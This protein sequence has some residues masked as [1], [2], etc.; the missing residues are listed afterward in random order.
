MKLPFSQEEKQRI[1]DEGPYNAEEIY[2]MTTAYS[3]YDLER[4]GVDDLIQMLHLKFQLG[5]LGDKNQDLGCDDHSMDN[6]K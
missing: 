6:A 3:Q 4:I 1:Y 2:N 5:R